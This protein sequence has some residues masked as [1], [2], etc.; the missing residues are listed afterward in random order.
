MKA[1][2][3]L[4]D[5]QK[6][7]LDFWQAFADYAFTKE[8]FKQQFSRRKPQ[9]QH[10]Y[11]LSVGSSALH[12]SLTANTQKKRIGA[13]IYNNDDKSIFEKLQAQKSEIEGELETVLEW[14]EANKAC[15]VLALT[16]GDIKKG[17]DVW[18][19]YFDWFCDMAS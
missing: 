19:E 12:I 16:G 11:D 14:R 6:L 13:K 4:S 8:T 15:R 10:W 17:P 2:E 3:G 7:Q 5:T 9:P 18:N 1:A